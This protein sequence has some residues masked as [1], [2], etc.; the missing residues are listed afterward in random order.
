MNIMIG[1]SSAETNNST[2]KLMNS[3]I[4]PPTLRRSTRLNMATTSPKSLEAEQQGYGDREEFDLQ[5]GVD[6][7]PGR[8]E[9]IGI[10]EIVGRRE[11]RLHGQR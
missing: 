2:K 4:A 9:L 7:R 6:P 8:E 11:V 10:L 3:R 1:A 5:G